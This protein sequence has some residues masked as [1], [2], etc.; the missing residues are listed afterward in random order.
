MKERKKRLAALGLFCLLLSLLLLPVSGEA[1]EGE[2]AAQE[3]EI[4]DEWAAFQA[5]I[6]AEVAEF[7][8]K[9]FF[10][11]DMTAVGDGVAKGGTLRATHLATCS[12]CRA[13]RGTKHKY[14]AYFRQ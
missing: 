1:G 14:A 3:A 2:L 9:D 7:L 10:S 6:P 4:A 12:P 11:S 13:Q 5:A 8:P